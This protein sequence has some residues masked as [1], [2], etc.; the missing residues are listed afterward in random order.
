MN[1]LDETLNPNGREKHIAKFSISSSSINL[2]FLSF[3]QQRNFLTMAAPPT[4]T[5]RISDLP[6]EIIYHILSYLPPKQIALTSLLSKR[7]KPLWRAMPNADR[8]S[9]LPFEV[10]SCILY[11]LPTKQF[12]V[13]AILSWRWR[14]VLNKILETN[15]IHY[16]DDS[17]SSSD[18]SDSDMEEEE[19]EEQQ[20]Y[21]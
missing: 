19:E 13:T 20:E 18:S 8:I 1:Q 14:R 4:T 11:N 17:D 9:A 6:D 3:N 7:W 16:D 15:H 2:L 5:D 21:V 12:F 10:L